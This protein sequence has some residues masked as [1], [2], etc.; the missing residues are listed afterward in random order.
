M[1]KGA[2]VLFLTESLNKS[3]IMHLA[4]VSKEPILTAFRR[5]KN[6]I[7][8]IIRAKAPNISRYQ[9]EKKKLEQKCILCPYIREGK[10]MQINS[11]DCEINKHVNCNTYNTIYM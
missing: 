9:R 8:P 7:N 11:I 10:A 1:G 3:Q 2:R 4:E 5:Q 6:V